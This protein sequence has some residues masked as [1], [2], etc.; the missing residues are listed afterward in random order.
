MET[1]CLQ[2]VVC[3]C[4][5]S[6]LHSCITRLLFSFHIAFSVA[7][8]EKH[9][10]RPSSSFF[11]TVPPPGGIVI[12]QVCLCACLF[13]RYARRCDFS[14][15]TSPTFMKFGD[16][17]DHLCCILLLTFESSRSKFKVKTAVLETFKS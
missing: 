7:S 2:H 5:S 12:R 3:F 17:V 10:N 8:V 15:N 11:F 4:H 14:K 6:A 9:S 1:E 16:D 13:V